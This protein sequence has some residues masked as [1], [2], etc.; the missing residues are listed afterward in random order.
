MKLHLPAALFLSISAASI[1]GAILGGESS[2]SGGDAESSSSNNKQQKASSERIN[3]NNLTITGSADSATT[4]LDSNST[5]YYEADTF[6]LTG[7]SAF[8]PKTPAALTTTS[9]PLP[10]TGNERNQQAPVQPPAGHQAISGRNGRMLDLDELVGDLDAARANKE[11]RAQLTNRQSRNLNGAQLEIGGGKRLHIQGFIPIVGI[12]EDQPDGLEK[13]PKDELVEQ[14]HSSA[15]VMKAHQARLKM[16]PGPSQHQLESGLDLPYGQSSLG[17]ASFNVQRY[18]NTDNTNQQSG[19][20]IGT[21]QFQPA[22]T[23]SSQLQQHQQQPVAQVK[24]AAGIVETLKRPIQKLTNTFGGSNNSDQQQQKLAQHQQQQQQQQQNCL[25][26]PF[27]MCKNGYISESGLGRSQIQQMILQQQLAVNT[28]QPRQ[29]TVDENQMTA[30]PGLVESAPVGGASYAN[31]F[32]PVDERSFE[33]ELAT[34]TSTSTTSTTASPPT[35]MLMDNLEEPNKDSS[36]DLQPAQSND[37]KPSDQQQQQAQAADQE[38]SMSP[39]QSNSSATLSSAPID[40]MTT[41]NQS[42]DYS[43]D[44]LGRML[45]LKANSR[46]SMLGSAS[47]SGQQLQTPQQ[48]SPSSGVCGLLRTCCNIPMSLFPTQQQQVALQRYQQPTL[49][50]ASA[51][52]RQQYHQIVTRAQSYVPSSASQLSYEPSSGALQP[53]SLYHRTSSS[54]FAA[55]QRPAPVAP[56]LGLPSTGLQQ[57]ARAPLGKQSLQSFQAPFSGQMSPMVGGQLTKPA[58][59]PPTNMNLLHQ[60]QQIGTMQTGAGI[61]LGTRKLLDGRCGL[62]QSAGINGRVQNLASNE[63]S[64]DFGEY[65]AQAAILKRLNGSES[66]F[67]CSGTLISQSWVATAAHC[68]RKHIGQGQLRVRL[69]EWDV[70]RDD[71]F[72]PYVEKEVRDLVIHPDFVPGNLINDIALVRLDSAIDPTLPHVN[73]AC[74]PA[75]DESFAGRRC[76]VAGWG[77]D[78]FGQQGAFQ[79]VL[80]EVELPVMGHAECESALRQTRL[81]PHYRLHPGF[82]CAGGEPGKDACEGDGG[83]GL[84]CVQEGGVIKVAGLVS[85]GI[86]CGQRNVPGVFVSMPHYRAWIENIIAIDDDIYSSYNPLPAN[87]LISERSPAGNSTGA[88]GGPQQEV[89]PSGIMEHQRA[90]TPSANTT[91]TAT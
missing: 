35:M 13:S 41:L 79:S 57:F 90:E 1:C 12:K 40:E 42:N 36:S 82:T 51:A 24:Q 26:V 18:L 81:G 54:D 59:I 14:L 70:H 17:H 8:K 76:W 61:Q 34:S 6:L 58:T 16:L 68:I 39:S 11:R 47:S 78:A 80:Q 69:G 32:V 10:P 7:K 37:A 3:G 28:Q 20:E 55:Q 49:V 62:R 46:V 48:Q 4:K 75:T 71:E 60:R 87:T 23:A 73:P 50:Q 2:G 5:F 77:K 45:G 25:C 30:R 89:S 65:P 67:V 19:L 38:A 56:M 27:Y 44:I 43:Q 85:W 29:P 72:Y 91:E 53:A 21:S 9:P 66:L 64:A 74:L 84:Y 31:S 22:L 83:S 63:N 15:S 88:I 86:S 52:P 33:R